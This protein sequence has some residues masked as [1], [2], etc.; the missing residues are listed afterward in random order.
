M[1]YNAISEPAIDNYQKL[2]L[3]PV[4][5]DDQCVAN[6]NVWRTTQVYLGGNNANA[7]PIVDLALSDISQVRMES[8]VLVWM[9]CLLSE[10][11]IQC[12]L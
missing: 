1:W 7:L 4:Y 5:L 8:T 12:L 6:D 3:Q 9:P 11:L 10:G 2:R